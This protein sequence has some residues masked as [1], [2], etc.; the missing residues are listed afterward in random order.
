MACAPDGCEFEQDC[1]QCH[2]PDKRKAWGCD[3]LTERSVFE[4]EPCLWCAGKVATCPHC[5]GTNRMPI[6]R[7]P[8]ALTS[9]RH[10]DVLAA[11]V[12]V[13]QGILPDG[14]GWQ[15]QAAT[16]V[17]AYPICAREIASWRAIAAAKA[18]AD[19]QRRS[20]AAGR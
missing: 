7:C 19:A 17:A 10:F 16:F 3:E 20:K 18:R 6:H 13:E 14:G 12:M 9:R 2:D 5:N 4:L 11:S 15:D 8:H 1:T